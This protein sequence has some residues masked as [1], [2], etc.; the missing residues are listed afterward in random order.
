MATFFYYAR[1]DSIIQSTFSVL[2]FFIETLSFI[3]V[4]EFA[5]HFFLADSVSPRSFV[6]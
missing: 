5:K 4:I 1:F 6:I 2:P 3:L